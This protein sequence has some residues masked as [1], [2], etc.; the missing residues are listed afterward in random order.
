[1]MRQIKNFARHLRLNRHWLNSDVYVDELGVTG[2]RYHEG[3]RSL[4]IDSE[5]GVGSWIAVWPES[6][7]R[8][9]PPYSNEPI[10]S[11]DRARILDNT[12][13]ALER[14]GLKVDLPGPSGWSSEANA[15][16]RDIARR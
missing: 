16:S 5:W 1:M 7:T 12:T 3:A 10:S 15:V 13:Q 14:A 4:F 11:T 8:W 6:I 2:L 9:D